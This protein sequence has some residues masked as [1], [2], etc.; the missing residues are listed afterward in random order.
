MYHEQEGKCAVTKIM[1]TNHKTSPLKLSCDRIDSSKGYTN[2][3]IQ[4]VCWFV[5]RMKWNLSMDEFKF[6]IGKIY[7]FNKIE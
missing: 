7:S 1:M 6:W 5:N 3:N 4:L 2:D